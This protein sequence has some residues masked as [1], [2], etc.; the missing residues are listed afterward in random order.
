MTSVTETLDPKVSN[1]GQLIGLLTQNGQINQDWFAHADTELGNI[2]R[3]VRELLQLTTNVLGK[4]TTPTG[5][6]GG[7]WYSIPNPTD[8]S[9]QTGFY[10][11]APPPPPS[12]TSPVN[13]TVGLG[14]L[15]ETGYGKLSITAYGYVP[16]FKL[17]SD[18]SPSF[19]IGTQPS[20]IGVVASLSDGETF[21]ANGTSFTAM[22]LDVNVSFS[23][24]QL[25]SMRLTF[26]DLK[27]AP[28]GVPSEYTSLQ[29]LIDNIDPAGKW[30]AAV[31]L[32]GSYWLDHYVGS[33][34]YTIGD[35]LT[36]AC[37]LT[38]NSDGKYQLNL[39]Y[40]KTNVKNPKV[41][42]ENFL[43]NL[44]HKLSDSDKPIVPIPA[45][46]K[47]SGIYVVRE[48]AEGDA[49]DY[50]ARLMINDIK[51]GGK[52]AASKDSPPPEVS[53]QIGKW[54]AGEKDKDS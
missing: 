30:L 34:A 33:S 39:D 2:P 7:T 8:K 38:V 46:G 41:L 11:V 18:A 9:K 28:A 50:G 43:F 23:S 4:G 10:L 13:A 53:F 1:V 25:P 44:L 21:K 36:A 15:Q 24:A 49:F 54:I 42:A 35:I 47:E 26:V 32:Q 52:A 5:V 51:V 14:V 48:K 19:V 29:Q 16:L 40:L 6:P 45:G 20:S 3:R 17:S 12:G 37:V 31:I 22:K 27:G